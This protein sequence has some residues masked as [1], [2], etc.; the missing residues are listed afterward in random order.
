MSIVRPYR[1]VLTGILACLS[2]SVSADPKITLSE[3][4]FSFG[5]TIQHAVLT[6]RFWI[7]SVGDTPARIVEV[8][9]DC[10]CTDLILADSLVQPNDSTALDLILH[11]R[12]FLGF[13]EK[14]PLIRIA[15]NNDTS[16]I[17]LYAEIMV[18][19]ESARPLVIAPDKVDVSQY[20]AK[21]RRKGTFTITNN[22]FSDYQISVV[23][24]SQ[25]SF[26]VVLPKVIKAGGKVEGQVI[27]HKTAVPTSF[28]ESFT[29]EIN[30]DG[31][32]RY[33]VPI[34]RQYQVKQAS[35]AP[36]GK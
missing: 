18:K 7:K 11:T 32:S 33:S 1:L 36:S 24:S 2:V 35:G 22:G 15:D 8:K 19:P 14:R 13:V 16:R 30:D 20:G 4:T 23:D 17:K 25:K 5:K 31:R 34:W 3:G 27:V 29:L 10:G 21:T 12:S 9:P 26:D 6:K 28:E